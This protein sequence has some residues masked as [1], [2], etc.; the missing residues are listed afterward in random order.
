MYLTFVDSDLISLNNMIEKI[1][2]PFHLRLIFRQPKSGFL[3]ETGYGLYQ[4]NP[5][6][7]PRND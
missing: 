6:I 5:I 7:H 1:F 2:L 3:L 4:V